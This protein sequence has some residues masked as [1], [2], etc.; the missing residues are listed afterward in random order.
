MTGFTL[1]KINYL[2]YGGYVNTYLL[3][4]DRFVI[5]IDSGVGS[6]K[7][8]ICQ[9][10]DGI[11]FADKP[12]LLLNTHMHWDHASLNGYLKERYGAVIC[13]ASASEWLCDRLRQ[14]EETYGAYEKSYPHEKS[15][16]EL[17]WR[18][19]AYPAPAD[20]VLVNNERIE[21]AGFSLRVLETPGHSADSLSFY[22]ENTGILFAGD[23]LQ[24]TG[25]DGNAPFYRSAEDYLHTAETVRHLP[26][27]EILC[28]H[29][30]FEG[31]PLCAKWAEAS[32]ETC[33]KLD[34]AV[35]KAEAA[36]EQA[37]GI[38]ALLKEEMGYPETVH[39]YTTVKAHM[40]QARSGYDESDCT[41]TEDKHICR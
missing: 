19:F 21:D 17:Y 30:M 25:F 29:G 9:E 39:L 10:L 1:K 3:E 7:K 41:K 16:R 11:D 26:M 28:G 2:F 22:E 31:A 18:E 23:A 4:T 15:I 24:G 27:K 40:T 20:R 36:G 12:F 33:E 34:R 32:V 14:F 35:R 6:A 13:G 38:C 37:T 5:L 8:T